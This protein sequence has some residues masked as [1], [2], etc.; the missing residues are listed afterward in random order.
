MKL[1]KKI[2][3]I[4]FICFTIFSCLDDTPCSFDGL[5][6]IISV[7]EITNG[8]VNQ[9]IEF[10]VTHEPEFGCSSDRDFEVFSQQNNIFFINQKIRTTCLCDADP[11]PM[12]STFVFTPIT[13][14]L[15]TF[16]FRKTDEEYI[17]RNVLVE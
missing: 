14:G 11:E 4:S 2:I 13:T 5:S 6:S 3:V 7:S 1:I 17:V 10:Q 8:S 16:R 9:I 12:T 15:F